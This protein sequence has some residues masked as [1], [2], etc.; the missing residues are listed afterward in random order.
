MMRRKVLAGLGSLLFLV[1]CGTDV[2]RTTGSSAASTGTT[3]G[4]ST[5]VGQVRPV[6]LLPAS[7]YY[8]SPV[9]A[10]AYT[11]TVAAYLYCTQDGQEPTE[12]S[13]RYLGPIQ[14][15]R[16]TLL[17]CR[18]FKPGMTPSEIAEATYV[19]EGTSPLGTFRSKRIRI[20]LTVDGQ[21]EIRIQDGVMDLIHVRDQQ[22][23]NPVVE[24]L[25][26]D[27][28]VE[29]SFNWGLTPFHVEEGI[30]CNWSPN[31][32][33]SAPFNLNLSDFAPGGF[34]YI[35]RSSLGV[36][37]GRDSVTVNDKDRIVIRDGQASWSGYWFVF[38]YWYMA[39]GN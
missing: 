32:C 13:P 35:P 23:G 5:E 33:V 21:D 1:S 34:G 38:E 17:R 37:V 10:T 27:N 3:T 31:G 24:I 39:T 4:A 9:T 11:E 26:A 12:S 14:I 20:S 22:P 25:K 30:T 2:E 18:A 8:L 28:S 6:Q 29:A 16:S 15:S 36:I 19:I 7:G